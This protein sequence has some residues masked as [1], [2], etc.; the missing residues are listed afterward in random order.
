MERIRH[1]QDGSTL[2]HGA[3]QR[4]LERYRS[5]R[6]THP[7]QGNDDEGRRSGPSPDPKAALIAA[8]VEDTFADGTET[9]RGD[10]EIRDEK[11]TIPRTV[12]TLLASPGATPR[13]GRPY[14]QSAPGGVASSF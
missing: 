2:I 1:R 6:D 7:V 5:R 4:Q 12:R 11:T 10:P 14:R 3:G 9:P 8:G 13:S